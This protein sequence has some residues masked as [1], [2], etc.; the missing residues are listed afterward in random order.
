MVSGGGYFSPGSGDGRSGLV[1]GVRIRG[2]AP[3]RCVSGSPRRRPGRKKD[4][5]WLGLGYGVRERK[6]GVCVR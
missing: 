2:V 5:W 4:E 3:V 6:G 1:A